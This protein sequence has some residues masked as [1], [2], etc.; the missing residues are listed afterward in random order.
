MVGGWKSEQDLQEKALSLRSRARIGALLLTRAKDGMSI[1]TDDVFHIPSFAREVYD[2]TGAGDT[3][4]AALA[5]FMA[6]G[7]SLNESAVLANKAAG[8]ACGK[9]GT[10]TVSRKE[11]ESFS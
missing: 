5:V 4:I 9:F 8:I 3:A 11:L 7:K 6:E 2:V 1:F 10:S